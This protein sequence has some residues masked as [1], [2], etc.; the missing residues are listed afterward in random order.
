MYSMCDIFAFQRAPFETNSFFFF[1][2]SQNSIFSLL[3]TAHLKMDSFSF[4]IDSLKETSLRWT[5]VCF[6]EVAGPGKR[7]S[8]AQLELR[9]VQSKADIENP[10]IVV[11]AKVIQAS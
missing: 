6:P 9:M 1:L 3:Y 5:A 11:N 8:P 4:S 7:P 10:A 2:W